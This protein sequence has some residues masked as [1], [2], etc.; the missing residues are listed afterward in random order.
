[1]TQQ[2]D[3]TEGMRQA[4]TQLLN[5]REQELAQTNY[6]LEEFQTWLSQSEANRGTF[7]TLENW[8]RNINQMEQNQDFENFLT[9]KPGSWLDYSHYGWKPYQAVAL[10]WVKEKNPIYQEI[11]SIKEILDHDQN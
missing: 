10:K 11:T 4:L 8:L 2:R 5:N 7:S 1:M 3:T 6:N 9:G